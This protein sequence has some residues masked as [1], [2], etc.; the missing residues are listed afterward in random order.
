[1]KRGVFDC[2]GQTTVQKVKKTKEFAL[3][4]FIDEMLYHRLDDKEGHVIVPGKTYVGSELAPFFDYAETVQGYVDTA[5]ALRLIAEELECI[6]LRSV[7]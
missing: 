2:I 3:A 5:K 7:T 1:M 4:H 6:A